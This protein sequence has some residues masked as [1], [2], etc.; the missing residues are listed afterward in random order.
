MTTDELVQYYG[1]LLLSQYEGLPLATGM[2]ESFVKPIIM[3]QL[4]NQIMNG[5]TIGTAVGPQLD[6]LGKYV[7]VKRS[8]VGV[9][10][11]PITL[12][13]SDFTTLIMIGIFRNNPKIYTQAVFASFLLGPPTNYVN[14]QFPSAGGFT[15][16]AID[17]FLQTFFQ[18]GIYC[19]DG[20]DMQ[21][22]Y[23][24]TA[25]VVANSDLLQMV[26]TQG[27][28]PKPMGVG[29]SNVIYLSA[30]SLFSMVSYSDFTIVAGSPR[31]NIPTWDG[32]TTYGI[33]QQVYFNGVVYKSLQDGNIG[34]D[35]FATVGFWLGVMF[36]M[37]EYNGYSNYLQTPAFQ[38]TWHWLSYSDV[39]F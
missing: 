15:L 1:N 5:F 12:S 2:V 28:L 13:D 39:N 18:G 19:Y 32:A 3:N 14:G 4:P 21:I 7:G 30:V 29:L 37:T 17:I 35:P 26:I 24:V 33:N 10:Q 20:L 34:N 16:F 27:L 8:G 23:L 25:T 6:V 38:S 11:Q 9:S 31:Y 22:S 36:P